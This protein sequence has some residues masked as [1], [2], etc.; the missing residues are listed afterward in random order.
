[1]GLFPLVIVSPFDFVNSKIKNVPYILSQ[2]IRNDVGLK[3]TKNG[4]F[5]VTG[6][7]EKHRLIDYIYSDNYQ[8]LSFWNF[9]KKVKP[10]LDSANLLR[11]N[12][13]I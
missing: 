5:Q 8:N 10:I 12:L 4:F 3:K 1:M 7:K 11:K 9:F 2:M 6:Y 13:N